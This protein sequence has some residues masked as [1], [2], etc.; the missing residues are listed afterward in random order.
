MGILFKEVTHSYKGY[1]KQVTVAIE[2]INLEIN[3]EGEFVAIVGKTGSGKSTL[4]QHMNALILPTSGEVNVFGNAIT[5]K[6][7]KKLKFNNIRKHV[8]YVFQFPEYQLFEQT[9]L[10]DIMFAPLNFGYQEA[11]AKKASVEVAKKLHITKLLN[12]SPFNL[13]GGQ[14]RKVAVAGILSY[15]PDILLLDEPTRGLDPKGSKDMMELF[16][17]IHKNENKTVVLISHDMNI[18]YKY[19][20]RIV[21]M[22]GA[23]I[24]FDGDK[25]ELFES[26]IYKDHHLEKPEVLKLIDYLNGKFNYNFDYNITSIDELVLKLKEVSHE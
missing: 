2:N 23:N 16:Y 15:N 4:V 8:G 19:A 5:A 12:H 1:K 6:K 17:D 3:S 25:K 14:Q 24:V 20:T 18:V 7:K 11:E 9:V 21:V 22:D 26:G 10:R 13:S